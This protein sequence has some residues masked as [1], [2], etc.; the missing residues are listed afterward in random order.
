MHSQPE[1]EA[2]EIY[3]H[4]RTHS[5]D[6]DLSALIREL[7]SD[8]TAYAPPRHAPQ[9]HQSMQLNHYPRRDCHQRSQLQTQPQQQPSLNTMIAPSTPVTGSSNQLPPLRSIIRNLHL[10]AA[11]SNNMQQPLP[12]TLS[13]VRPLQRRMSPM[14]GTSNGS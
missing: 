1:T 14:S 11:G 2:L 6:R 10:P 13:P 8:C 4:I 12:Q 7:T 5:Q 9:Q 3:R